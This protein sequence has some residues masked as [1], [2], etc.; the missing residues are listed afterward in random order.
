[1]EKYV[2]NFFEIDKS[3]LPEVGGKGANLGEMTKAGMPVPQGFCV[4]TTAYRTFIQTSESIVQ[5]FTQLDHIK[6]DD[7]ERIRVYGQQIRDH[8]ISL[9]M[10]EDIHS[11]ILKAWKAQGQNKA[12][13]VRSSATA[14]D[15]PTA[16]FAGQQ[17]TYLNI[18]GLES[19]LGAIQRCWA[20]L[21]TDRAISYRAKNGFDHR[22][23]FLS[24]VVQEMVFPGVAGIM[25]TAD[26]ITGQRNTVSI[27][28]SFGLGEALVSGLVTADLYQV[29]FG[30]ITKKQISKKE[31]A[32]Y[33]VPEG[34]T[35]TKQLPLE[36][37]QQQALPDQR[38]IELAAI[39]QRI[40]THYG[41]EQDI[42]WGYA[43]GK[44]YILQS[45]PITSLYPVPQVS[46]NHFHV[47]VNFGYIQVMTDPMKPLAMSLMSN[48]TG[49]LK[50][51]PD[52]HA[53]QFLREAGGRA[54]ADFTGPLSIK[55]VR[56]RLL[57]VF[58]GMDELLAAALNEVT[59]RDAFQQVSVPKKTV[60]QVG[61]KM[62]PILIPAALKVFNNLRFKNPNH[63]AKAA[64]DLIE[65]IVA[66]T[67][68]EIFGT[69]G[70]ERI[71][72]VRH[73]MGRMLPDVLSKVAVYWIAGILT[74]GRLKKMLDKQF[75]E[76]RRVALLN[77]LNKSLPGNVTAEMGLSLGDLADVARLYPEVT[78]HLQRASDSRFY[79]ELANITGGMEFRHALDCFLQQYGMRA[80]G[81]ID[82]TKPRWIEE[83]ILLV[84]SILSNIRT[85]SAGEHRKKFKQGELEA[86]EAVQEITAQYPP[87]ERRTVS[88]LIQQYRTLMGMR[89]HHKFVLV[90]VMY[91]YKRAILEEARALV[92]KGAI[93]REEDVFY[94]TLEEIIEL[95]ENRFTGNVQEI[96]KAREKQYEHN[97]KLKSPR[98]MTSEGEII[99]G[100][101]REGN[102]PAGAI[103]GTPVSAGV[104][105]GIARVVLKP[106]EA[107]LQ[108]GEIL[109]APYTDPGWTPLFISA[110]GLITEVGGM[111]THGSVVAREY[112]IPAVVGIEKATEI[113]KDG[114]YVRVD[115]T[116][117]FV[118]VL[119]GGKQD[120]P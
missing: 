28:A 62:V 21:F 26:P 8:L 68:K 69:S 100:K 67:E 30:K 89:E 22:N 41:L 73:S 1:M 91:I 80:V 90:I 118:Q 49:F 25:F 66:H 72:L 98:V 37:Q 77:K 64:N 92:R 99:T 27:D 102:A 61:R 53:F 12:Y 33:G 47:F 35:V 103:I 60:M 39:G 119:N 15:L 71:R 87:Q 110:V 115:G 7:L 45:R 105:E 31:I 48:I 34:G 16:S 32:I 38:I 76:I 85:S 95:I 19:L 20:S 104:V 43:E 29:R 54:F 93:R 40:E 78:Q 36:Q 42:E 88:R 59:K 10:P 79:D 116:N 63:A 70:S 74:S 111:M 94:F 101:L 11:A 58:G 113:I 65:K 46:D 2:L 57:K 9:R 14:E 56:N 13:A 81:E 106:E 107:K 5:L 84:P 117:G 23:V 114:S 55:P 4:T 86:V 108:P 44:F 97:L 83:P 82:I 50:K 96:V 109:V 51:S 6:H 120:H 17:D 75:G 3:H 52:S 24:V 18:C 112:G